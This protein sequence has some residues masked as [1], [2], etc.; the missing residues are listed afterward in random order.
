MLETFL[1]D[2]GRDR[3]TQLLDDIVTKQWVIVEMEI[4]FFMSKEHDLCQILT[5][6][7]NQYA[8]HQAIFQCFHLLLILV[9]IVTSVSCS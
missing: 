9:I 2:F 6:H 3:V 8:S 4:V 5:L 7:L 1:T